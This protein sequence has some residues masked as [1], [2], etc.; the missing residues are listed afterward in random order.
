MDLH[1]LKYY[2]KGNLVIVTHISYKFITPTFF[3][4]RDFC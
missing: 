1:S 4:T 2:T 3:N